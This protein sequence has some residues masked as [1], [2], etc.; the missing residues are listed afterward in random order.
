MHAV[1]SYKL[2]RFDMIINFN[3]HFLQPDKQSL[4]KVEAPKKKL[5]Y[6]CESIMISFLS[7]KLESI[8]SKW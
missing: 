5:Q 6:L 7:C 2:V 1:F 4:K 3:M 8:I